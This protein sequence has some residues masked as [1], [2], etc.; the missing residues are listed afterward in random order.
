M[1]GQMTRRTPR[2]MMSAPR[3]IIQ[4]LQDEM[5]DM[6]TRFF[7]DGRGASGELAP[8]L[9]VSE[10]ENEIEVRMDAPGI[11]PENIDIQLQGNL[12]TI[13][14]NRSEEKEEKGRTYHRVERSMGSF[15][16]TI[17]LPCVVREEQVDAQYADGILTIRMP[18]PE[19]SRR[20]KIE[21][22]APGGS[23]TIE[24]QSS[25]QTPEENTGGI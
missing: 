9:D 23:H 11:K 1:A 12:L 13:S 20:R 4:R 17:T 3:D 21:V 14:G 25:M 6:I 22:K 5:D 7:G 2:E 19:E 16:R 10:T 15:S 18:K 24:Q 8:L